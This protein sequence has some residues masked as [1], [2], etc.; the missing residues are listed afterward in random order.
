M[1]MYRWLIGMA[2]AI[3]LSTAAAA[4][5]DQQKSAPLIAGNPAVAPLK[6]VGL[7]VFKNA[8]GDTFSCTAQ[9]IAPKVLLTAA[10]CVRDNTTG[11]WYDTN[12]MFFFLQY[13]NNNASDVYKVICTGHISGWVPTIAANATDDEKEAAADNAFQY[14][15]AMILVNHE[16]ITGQFKV[17]TDWLGKHPMATQIGYP[18]A[19]AG[20]MIVQRDPGVLALSLSRSNEIILMHGN[21]NMTQGTSGGAWIANFDTTESPNENV[22]VGLTSFGNDTWPGVTFGPYLRQESYGGLFD[23]VSKGCP[24]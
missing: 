17:E 19:I 24:K 15:Y 23:Y 1:S 14:D 22:I 20:G 11:E 21:R 5:D 18:G 16:S 10:H 3:A 12:N 13:Q 8:K 9:F 7:L 4:A 2:A 6:W